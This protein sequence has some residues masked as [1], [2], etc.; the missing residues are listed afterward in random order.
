MFRLYIS[1]KPT[2]RQELGDEL[3]KLKKNILK[4]TNRCLL[5]NTVSKCNG[6]LTFSELTVTYGKENIGEAYQ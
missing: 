4:L 6:G 5:W 3:V 1:D 2:L